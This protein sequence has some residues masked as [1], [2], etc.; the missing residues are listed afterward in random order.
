MNDSLTQ[1]LSVPAVGDGGNPS[2]LY[3]AGKTAMRVLVRNN[4]GV[5]LFIAH[6]VG[7]LANASSIGT[8][9]QLPPAQSDVFVIAPGQSIFAASNGAGGVASVAISEA[10]PVANKYLES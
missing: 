2:R 6:D 4:G 9:Y 10:V 5:I 3:Q 7:D 1:T 8:S